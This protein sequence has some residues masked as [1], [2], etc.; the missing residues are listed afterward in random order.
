MFQRHNASGARLRL[1]L[2]KL[3]LNFHIE[4]PA[5]KRP[6]DYILHRL[7]PSTLGGDA[8][9][10]P[11]KLQQGNMA[12]KVEA[13]M[14]NYTSE[15]MLALCIDRRSS[16]ALVFSGALHAS[17]FGLIHDYRDEQYEEAKDLI[18]FD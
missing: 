15:H 8:D 18:C 4:T 13:S 7:R 10:Q 5:V 16:T 14:R 17:I 1:L 3:H 6:S 9:S 12:A 2:G 11:A